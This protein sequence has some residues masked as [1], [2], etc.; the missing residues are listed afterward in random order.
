MIVI[1]ATAGV[2]VTALGLRHHASRRSGR[3]RLALASVVVMA[4]CSNSAVARFARI[5][6]SCAGTASEALDPYV[7]LAL[8]MSNL[9]S[10]TRSLR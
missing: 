10:W 7:E 5:S 3:M 8:C 1:T 9:L 2:Q 6:R 4:S